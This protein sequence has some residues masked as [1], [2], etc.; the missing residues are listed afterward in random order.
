MTQPLLCGEAGVS[1][2]RRFSRIMTIFQALAF[3][4][5]V[6]W[7]DL[8]KHYISAGCVLDSQHP[9][10]ILSSPCH[11]CYVVAAMTAL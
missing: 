8:C 9:L 10:N 7:C 11:R 2:T 4:Y 5:K 6:A 1:V 3:L